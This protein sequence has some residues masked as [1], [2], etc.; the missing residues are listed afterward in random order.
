MGGCPLPNRNKS[1]SPNKCY[2]HVETNSIIAVNGI[3]SKF[4][5][6][7]SSDDYSYV[8]ATYV[9][10]CIPY[11][12]YFENIHK[13]VTRKNTQYYPNVAKNNFRK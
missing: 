7:T 3:K 13:N 4:L 6:C 10:T 2:M 12:D 8:Y 1:N 11:E 5:P 9:N